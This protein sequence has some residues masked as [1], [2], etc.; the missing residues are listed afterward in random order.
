MVV[1]NAF[2][3]FSF[4]FFSSYKISMLFINWRFVK[5]LLHLSVPRFF[6]RNGNEKEESL[7]ERWVCM[8]K[9]FTMQWVYVFCSFFFLVLYPIMVPSGYYLHSLNSFN[10]CLFWFC[11]FVWA[12]VSYLPYFLSGCWTRRLSGPQNIVGKK[13]YCLAA[14]HHVFFFW[15]GGGGSESLLKSRLKHQ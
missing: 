4:T 2:H 6:F 3:F 12:P 10:Y 13:K 8:R 14:S 11:C 15:G 1:K 9:L 5:A 7:K